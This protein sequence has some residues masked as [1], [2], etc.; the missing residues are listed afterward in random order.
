MQ[1]G[2]NF[3]LGETAP[4]IRRL[5]AGGRIDYVELL[6]DNFLAIPATEIARA[7]DA[8]VGLH[9]MFS[10]FIERPED[11][12]QA[13]AGRL[14][15]IIRATRPLYVSDHIARF[16]HQGRH[17][18]HLAEIDYVA[19]FEQVAGRVA[20][21]QEMLGCRIAFENYPSIMD[22]GWDAPDFFRR[23][24]AR[25]G[26]A[27]LFDVSNAI[28]ANHNCG[29]PITDWAPVIREA[30]HFHVAGY[31][32]SIGQPAITLDTHDQALADDTRAA[33]ATCRDLGP[34]PDATI[35][36][37]RDDDIDEERIATDLDM[38]RAIFPRGGQ[39]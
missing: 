25:T 22:G 38:L 1:I 26:C 15:A 19:D 10:K 28:C 34:P 21:W 2:F 3:T 29:C 31:R 23:L 8:P 27:V 39:P 32:P 6:I 35:T 24:T 9:I 36:Y 7:F 17:L 33:L 18:L 14:R 37:E 12:L 16:T 4:M 30:R 20:R 5:I 13:L 11:E